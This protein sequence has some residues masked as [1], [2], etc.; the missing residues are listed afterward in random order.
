MEEDTLSQGYAFDRSSVVKTRL[1]AQERYVLAR[2][3][4]SDEAGMATVRRMVCDGMDHNGWPEHRRVEE[5]AKYKARCLRSG[6]PNKFED[7]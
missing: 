7:R 4:E 3:A 2:L 1:P 6:E 5:Y